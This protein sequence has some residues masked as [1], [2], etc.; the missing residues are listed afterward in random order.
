[1]VN[2]GVCMDFTE[3]E[4]LAKSYGTRYELPKVIVIHHTGGMVILMQ[5]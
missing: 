2:K 1:M 3:I 4:R 5:K